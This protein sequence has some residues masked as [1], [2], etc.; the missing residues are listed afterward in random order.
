VGDLERNY[1]DYLP[2]KLMEAQISLVSGDPKGTQRISNELI[3]RLNKSG[4]DNENTPQLLAELRTK[5]YIAR[6]A[7]LSQLGNAAAARQDFMAAKEIAP[8][9]SDVYINLAALSMRENKSDE[10]MGF[11]EN[12]LS[13]S[14]TD[15]SAL[16]GLINVYAKN[17]QL[18]K[19][20]ARVD[21]VLSSYPNMA[22]LHYLKAQVYGFQRNQQGAEAELRKTIELDANYLPAYSALGAL[23]VNTKQEDRAIEEYKKIV[24]IRPDNGTAYTLI[25]MLYDAKKDYDAAADSYRKALEKD[26]NNSIAANNL[27]WLYATQEG[28]GN[29]DDAVRLAQGVVQRNSNTAGFTDTLGWVYYKKGLQGVAVEQLQKAV[30]LDEAAARAAN[31][32]PSPAY[33][34]HLG[35]ALKAK[36]DKSGARRELE[37]ALKLADKVPFADADEARKALATL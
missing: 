8:G 1:P 31:V 34:Y 33:R 20:H 29:L 13:A 12:A 32:S 21:Q 7:A 27:A 5:A 24:A 35:M 18:D 26:P 10:A 25:G 17:N 3:D 4:P 36:G 15:L 22:G 14:A 37:A 28:K 2:A 9:N 6:G 11:Y 30:S 23:F 16:N 19:A